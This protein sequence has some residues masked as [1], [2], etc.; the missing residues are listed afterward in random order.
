MSL[1]ISRVIEQYNVR[2]YW[3][4]FWICTGFMWMILSLSIRKHKCI[5][6]V[7]AKRAH[8]VGT[9]VI[10]VFFVYVYESMLQFT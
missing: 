9:V 8:V 3:R 1:L 7:H 5:G 2:T 6:L 10:C 4:D